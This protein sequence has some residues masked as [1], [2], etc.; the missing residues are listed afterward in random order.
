[1]K[2]M[3]MKKFALA[4]SF[5]GLCV[6]TVALVLAVGMIFNK[7]FGWFSSNSR[8]SGTGMSVRTDV[9][10]IE[11]RSN[12]GL[13]VAEADYTAGDIEDYY[14]ENESYVPTKYAVMAETPPTLYYVDN[15]ATSDYVEATIGAEGV[16]A[17]FKTSTDDTHREALYT[18]SAGVATASSVVPAKT[19][20]AGALTYFTPSNSGTYYIRVQSNKNVAESVGVHENYTDETNH[21]KS[22]LY[23]VMVNESPTRE[24]NDIAPGAFGTVTFQII[25]K[26]SG[27]MTLTLEI[28]VEGI[29]KN[30]AFL[31]TIDTTGLT[32]EDLAAANANNALTELLQGH[33]LL[34]TNRTAV[35]STGHYNYSGHIDGTYELAPFTAVAGTPVDVEIYWVWPLNFAQ[36]VLD[37]ID[38]RQRTYALFDDTALSGAETLEH[39]KEDIKAHPDIIAYNVTLPD[40]IPDGFEDTYFDQF[41]M[42]YTNGDQ[43][44]GDNIQYIVIS[45]DVSGSLTSGGTP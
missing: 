40:P 42:G 14:S 26:K 10:F 16:N 38:A 39:I 29:K 35:G 21:G 11:L 32:G 13:A 24:S 5:A 20:G 9:E 28:N 45:V 17:R 7:S 30:N 23:C 12:Y 3:T 41:N 4:G 27:T 18:I 15:N 36:I 19:D 1:M 31:D 44:I 6:V 8:T 33:I 43:H 34:F 37:D 25:P 22:S 2:K